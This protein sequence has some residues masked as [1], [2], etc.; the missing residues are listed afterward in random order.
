VN[1]SAGGV[2][3]FASPK[4]AIAGMYARGEAVMGGEPA[5]EVRQGGAVR[6][7]EWSEEVF[8]CSC[9]TFPMSRS[10]WLPAGVKCSA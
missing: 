10:R 6:L 7:I 9:A 1:T 3:A 4:G 5:E 8:P 2:R